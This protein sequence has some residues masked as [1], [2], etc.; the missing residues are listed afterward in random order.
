MRVYRLKVD[1]PG[2]DKGTLFETDKDYIEWTTDKTK[3]IVLINNF[4]FE[5][6]TIKHNELQD[7]KLERLLE[8]VEKL[9]AEVKRLELSKSN[10]YWGGYKPHPYNLGTYRECSCQGLV[11]GVCNCILG[12]NITYCSN[13]TIIGPLGTYKAVH[14]N[15]N[16]GC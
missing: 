1:L 15:N 7:I 10:N 4:Y 13:D 2:K 3:V 16:E 11:G 8:R 6:L 14:K 12:T 5:E 9:E